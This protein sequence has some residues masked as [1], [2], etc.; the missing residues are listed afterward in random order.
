MATGNNKMAEDI[1]DLE[2]NWPRVDWRSKDWRKKGL[3]FWKLRELDLLM[4]NHEDDPTSEN[5]FTASPTSCDS[6]YYLTG[7]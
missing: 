4:Q 5:D 2:L 3:L 1:Q 6:P 7:N